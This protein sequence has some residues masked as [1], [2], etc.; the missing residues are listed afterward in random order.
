ME[1]GLWALYAAVSFVLLL[2]A[3]VVVGDWR[4]HRRERHAH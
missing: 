1:T 2:D 4:A 3:W